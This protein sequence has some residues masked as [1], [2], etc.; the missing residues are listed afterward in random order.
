MTRYLASKSQAYAVVGLSQRGG[1][2]FEQRNR[3]GACAVTPPRVTPPE[4]RRGPV[5]AAS[6]TLKC[7]ATS[8]T[9]SD[10]LVAQIGSSRLVAG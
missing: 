4:R 6:A 3:L 1:A 9:S 2:P 8:P 5:F 7:F 10:G